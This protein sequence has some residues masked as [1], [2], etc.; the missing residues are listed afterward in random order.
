MPLP[1]CSVNLGQHEAVLK[2]SRGFQL[3]L[4]A[5]VDGQGIVKP[6][7]G[8]SDVSFGGTHG[9]RERGDLE[10]VHHLFWSDEGKT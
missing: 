5:L 3:V 2:L 4:L 7:S 10:H 1:R 6:G 8:Q 9:H